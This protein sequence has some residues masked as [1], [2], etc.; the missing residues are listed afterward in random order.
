MPKGQKKR[1]PPPLYK[2]NRRR[3]KTSEASQT[4]DSEPQKLD[5]TKLTAIQVAELLTREGGRQIELDWIKKDFVAGMPVN[6]PEGTINVIAYGAW[7]LKE[8][9]KS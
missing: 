8:E 7:L 9:A 1:K 5:P 2:Q 6:M 3:A 4:S